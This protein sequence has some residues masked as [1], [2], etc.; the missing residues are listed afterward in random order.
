MQKGIP[1]AEVYEK[2][3]A[4]FTKQFKRDDIQAPE[5]NEI[6]F[7]PNKKVLEKRSAE[8]SEETSGESQQIYKPIRLSLEKMLKDLEN[9]KNSTDGTKKNE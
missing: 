6:V 7:R 9:E 2:A 5:T 1:E 4:E 8:Y 3:I